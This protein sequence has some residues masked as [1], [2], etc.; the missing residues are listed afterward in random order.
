MNKQAASIRKKLLLIATKKNIAYQNVQTMFLLERMVA[1]LTRKKELFDTIIFKGGY[2]G[3]RVFNSPRYTI[4]LDALINNAEINKLKTAIIN[5]IENYIN[6]GTW[7][8]YEKEAELITLGEYG[9]TRLYFRCGIGVIPIKYQKSQ[10]IH[11]D[12]VVGDVVIPK[13]VTNNIHSLIDDSKIL[14][15]TYTIESATAEK[16]HTLI[17]RGSSN[18]RSKDLFDL[19]HFLP[20]CDVTILK[21]ALLA[22]FSCRDSIFPINFT[23]SVSKIDRDLLELGWKNATVGLLKKVNLDDT[24]EMILKFCKQIDSIQ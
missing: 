8:K 24:F 6:D 23:Q 3:L 11:F 22:T 15:M 12:A 18:S 4:D 21:K 10:S 19:Y 20:R 7:F 5:A 13:P 17:T 14:W 9:G 16:L 2:V 1:R